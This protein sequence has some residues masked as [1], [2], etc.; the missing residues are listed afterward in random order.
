MEITVSINSCKDCRHRDH[1]GR[2]TVRGARL[3]CGHS[4]A[5]DCCDKRDINDFYQEY[6]E[7]RKDFSRRDWKFHWY[8]RITDTCNNIPNWCPLKYGRSY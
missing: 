4:E 5:V 3:I 6:P 7:Y 1:S 2:F 8:N